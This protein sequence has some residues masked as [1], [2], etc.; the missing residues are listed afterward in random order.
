MEIVLSGDD[1][2]HPSLLWKSSAFSEVEPLFSYTSQICLTVLL[3]ASLDF[4]P[5]FIPYLTDNLIHGSPLNLAGERRVISVLGGLP[6]RLLCCVIVLQ[7]LLFPSFE[8]F[9]CQTR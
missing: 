6:H 2:F 8:S 9:F 5:I 1:I 7:L 3:V 4:S